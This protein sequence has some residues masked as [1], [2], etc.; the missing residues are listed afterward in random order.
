MAFV[1]KQTTSYFWPVTVEM[2][3]DGGRFEKQTFDAEFRR[4]NQSRI[5]TIMADAVASQIRDVD[6]ASEVMV[7]WKGIT[8]QGDEVPFSEK[9]KADLLDMPLVASAVIKAWMESLAGAKRKN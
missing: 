9:S 4:M 7:G 8:D 1:L 2:P 5:E 3:A 6:V